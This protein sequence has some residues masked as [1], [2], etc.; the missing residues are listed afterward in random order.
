MYALNG[1]IKAGTLLF[2]FLPL[3]LIVNSLLPY[4]LQHLIFP[5][6][7]HFINLCLFSIPFSLG[8]VSKE[9]ISFGLLLNL[10]M[11]HMKQYIF[12]NPRFYSLGIVS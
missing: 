9:I 12:D 11:V 1:V 4:T 10:E 7:G 2:L 5:D 8:S 3:F 6:L